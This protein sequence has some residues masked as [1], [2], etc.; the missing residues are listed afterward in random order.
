MHVAGLVQSFVDSEAGN[1]R[2]KEERALLATALGDV[3]AMLGTMIGYLTSSQEDVR[4]P[5]QG[6]PA[7]GPVPALPWATW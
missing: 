5:L 2:L 1:G 7:R 3:Q 6:R 4:Q